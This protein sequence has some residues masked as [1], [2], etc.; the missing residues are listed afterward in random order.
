[1]FT[2]ELASEVPE[3]KPF[4]DKAYPGAISTDLLGAYLQSKGVAGELETIKAE[5]F[6]E[7]KARWQE[8]N[9]RAEGFVDRELNQGWLGF[10]EDYIEHIYKYIPKMLNMKSRDTVTHE[11][12]NELKGT[13]LK[14]EA[15]KTEVNRKVEEKMA[16]NMAEYNKAIHTVI[17][18]SKDK[19]REESARS[20]GRSYSTFTEA[21]THGGFVPESM[22]MTHRF[23]HWQTT[24]SEVIRNK[25]YFTIASTILDINDEMAM[26]PVKGEIER[27]A[28]KDSAISNSQAWAVLQALVRFANTFDQYKREPLRMDSSTDPWIQI[29]RIVNA[30]GVELARRGFT[31]KEVPGFNLTTVWV[32]E[33]AP[34]D[35]LKHITSKGLEDIK[36]S[37]GFLYRILSGI[38]AFNQFTKTLALGFS[39]F[40]HF[41]LMETYG[42]AFGMAGSPFLPWN[43][44]K[45]SKRLYNTYKSLKTDSRLLDKWARVGLLAN[46]VPMESAHGAFDEALD[47]A[48]AGAG[49]YPILRHVG[50]GPLRF[51]RAAKKLNDKFLWEGLQPAMKM[52]LAEAL[53]NNAQQD[54]A[55]AVVPTG[56]LMHDI[57][58]YVNDNL[59]GQEWTQ[60][61]WAN[62]FSRDILQAFMFAPDWTISSITSAGIPEMITGVTGASNWL[63]RPTFTGFAADQKAL[64]YWPTFVAMTLVAVPAAL[65]A[66]IYAAFGDPDEDDKEFIGDNEVG[67]ET[68]VDL[69]PIVRALKLKYGITDR[70]RVYL[71][72]GKQGYEIV[73]WITDPVGTLLGKSS[74]T[75][76]TAMEQ[77]LGI[78]SARW[79]MPWKEKKGA[80]GLM[81]LF[82]VDGKFTKSRM[83]YMGMKFM[84]MSVQSLMEGKP[85]TFFA[86]ARLGASQFEAELSLIPLIELYAGAET[87]EATPNWFNIHKRLQVLTDQVLDGAQ[88]NGYDRKEVW[89]AALS[90]VKYRIGI[91]IFQELN[92]KPEPR[93]EK[94]AEFMR[95]Y[96]RAE[97]S[98]DGIY[99]GVSNKLKKA[100]RPFT[101]EVRKPLMDAWYAEQRKR[102]EE[103]KG[104]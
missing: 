48:I 36:E 2:G 94:L 42:A 29:E 90:K 66:A 17:Q 59:G 53:L 70:R 91:E 10:R 47:A 83:W 44:V 58:Q 104:E 96:R 23:T 18:G 97:G 88:A 20:E 19:R 89:S 72:W 41:S 7:S 69:T 40:H 28:G 85:S 60:Y 3:L 50:G 52:E 56:Q 65:Q 77:G 78:N 1:V 51:L 63:S 64:T 43:F 73:G 71:R 57:A 5:Y 32:R 99:K 34:A 67:R 13:E 37:N 8:A 103:Q 6:T 16:A 75:V 68:Y 49:K 26:I 27:S 30:S 74:M 80:E 38:K 24:V 92:H 102:R 95:M 22:Q 87:Q 45:H 31:Q 100:N 61:M 79:D 101:Q 84:P 82:K 39:M 4:A 15:L 93:P 11:V 54:P 46:V 21:G 98:F 76:K 9:R 86:P 14:G 55:L 81:S 12:V 33:G 62:P 25:K 35:L